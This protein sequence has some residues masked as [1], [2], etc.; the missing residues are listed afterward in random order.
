MKK[1]T[2]LSEKHKTE[3]SQSMQIRGAATHNLRCVDIDL[4]RGK[5]IVLTGVSGSGKS[6]LAFDTLF[7]ESQ[8]QYLQSLSTYTR[9]F[10]D[11]ME[12]PKLASVRGLQPCLSID[13]SQGVQSPRS[14]VGTITELYDYLRL[15]MARVAIPSCYKCNE[16]I[17]RQSSEAIVAA[18]VRA[19][20]GTKLTIMAPMVLDRKGAHAD[21]F[22][23]IEKAGLLK[24]RV[25]G[26]L[27]ELDEIPKLAVR[28]EHTIEA[29]V[30]RIVV[31]QESRERIE[32]AIL[33]GLQLTSGLVRTL[34][35][36]QENL[37]STRF[38]CVR[39][40]ISLPEIEPRTFSFNSAYGACPKC[41]GYGTI[42][43]PREKTC[44]ACQGTRLKQESLAIR[45][46]DLSIA[47]ITAQSIQEL[48]IW[49]GGLTWDPERK[50]I[51]LPIL[52]E[53]LPRLEYLDQVGLGYLSLDRPGQTLSGGEL[54]RVR[55]ATS[56]GTGLTGVCYVLDEPSIGLH[57]RDTE[58]L[59]GILKSL[60][61]QGNS[62]VVV[63]HDE[64]MMRAAD[65]VVDMGPAAGT[66]GG[67]VV[68]Q[69]S[70]EEIIQSPGSLTGKYLAADYSMHQTLRRSIDKNHPKLRIEGISKNN[71]RDVT[72]EFPIG[73]LIAISGVSGSGK[74][75]LIHD[76]LVPALSG[77]LTD[78][79]R[80]GE[81]WRNLQGADAIER[82][83][84]ID[85]SPIGRS[86]RSTPATYCGF[87][88]GVRKAFAASRDAKLRGYQPN[89]F[90]FNAGDGRCQMCAGAGRVKL[91]MSFLEQVD[92]PCAACGGKRFNRSTLSIKY[93][94][95][96]IADVLEMSMDQAAEFFENF[97]D[98][99]NALRCL[100]AVGLG[101]LTLGQRSTTLSGGEAQ[102]IK[103]AT[104]LQ[105][106]SNGSTVYVLDE[107]T[108]GLHLADIERV[109]RLL[110]GLVDKGNTIIIVE[111]QLDLISCC[112]WII[113]LGPEGGARGGQIVGVG[114][115]EQIAKLRTPTGQALE[116]FLASKR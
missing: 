79:K 89:R 109:V 87:W 80:S 50:K 65:L 116:Q 97:P 12:R 100:Q 38:A 56:V 10:L 103:L 75:T 24:V 11:Q 108:T 48:R 7:A 84:E 29:V 62:I 15:L 40:G 66:Q 16:P 94:E 88:D 92:V 46:Q 39:C 68:A 35:D 63:E 5:F 8:R 99:Q 1:P 30:D 53:I 60:R 19:S 52:Q 27:Y 105:K 57:S 31:R 3:N 86:P 18:V 96:N 28:K 110:L 76:T 85:Q 2:A 74:S 54:Q 33:D 59:I 91:E 36:D 45:L 78:S 13:Q 71:L 73:R 77:W 37:Y 20:E 107:P 111:H 106:K 72:V 23:K 81:H 6:S 44:P 25:D 51:A 34:A 102:R 70:L 47:Q 42:G 112:D 26:Q 64:S 49:L 14:T 4:P 114:T 21:V 55:L 43:D 95:K 93:K 22:S 104:E 61:G 58:R 32:K 9:Q 115:P 67:T 113:D 98:L 83:L 69:G 41:E 101:Y 17:L 82:L 90:S